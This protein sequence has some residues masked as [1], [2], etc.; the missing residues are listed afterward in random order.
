MAD[1]LIELQKQL[2]IMSSEPDLKIHVMLE[3]TK[4]KKNTSHDG[5]DAEVTSTQPEPAAIFHVKKAVLIKIDYFRILL[6]G[7]F[8]KSGQKSVTLRGDDTFALDIWFRLLHDTDVEDA[9]AKAA[10]ATVRKVITVKNEYGMHEYGHHAQDWFIELYHRSRS[11]PV[12][13]SP[14]DV[15]HQLR[16]LLLPAHY[17][18]AD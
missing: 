5:V 16:M 17:F 10:M 14:F 13:G 11:A 9:Y 15:N 7:G 18:N 2:G 1:W 6:Q 3:E 8:H 12:A 4:P